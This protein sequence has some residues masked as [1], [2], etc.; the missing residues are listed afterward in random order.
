MAGMKQR[1]KNKLILIL[2]LMRCKHYIKNLLL[3]APLFFGGELFDLS[4][5]GNIV[6]GFI[7]FSMAASFVY[8]INDIN[9]KEKDCR[10]PSKCKRPIASG[11]ITVDCAHFVA[12]GCFFVSGI[13]GVV[14]KVSKYYIL[15]VLYIILNVFYSKK[16]KN[17]PLI[18]VTILVAGFVI[19]ISYGGFISSISI[20]AWLYMTIISGAFYLGLG[21]RRNE[22]KYYKS[23]R[24][25]IV[26][27]Y[28]N[29]E[30]LDKNMY[31]CMG[32]CNT[33]YAL[34]TMSQADQ[35]LMCTVPVILLISMKYSLLIEEGGDADP[36][37][38]ILKDKF[39]LILGVIYIGILMF[40]LY[41]K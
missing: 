13:L 19:R 4:K 31:M 28:Y 3:F 25:R 40:T 17:V 10:H 21:K 36:M 9:D 15:I 8:I 23:K 41:G 20:S 16:L 34:W 18:D 2:R 29:Y 26:M 32:L 30:F 24:T 39:I 37:E 6:I 38:I 11:E 33:F 12:I 27:E 35:L 5:I 14:S 1:I 22:L 7:S